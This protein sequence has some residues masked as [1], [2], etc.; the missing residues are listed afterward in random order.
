MDD[1]KQQT[2]RLSR[3]LAAKQRDLQSAREELASLHAQ[4]LASPEE[5]STRRLTAVA[6]DRVKQVKALTVYKMH[7]SNKLKP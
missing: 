6:S 3:E 2:E 1:Q 5:S 4:R 7:A